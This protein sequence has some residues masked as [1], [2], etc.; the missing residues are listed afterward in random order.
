MAEMLHR[1]DIIRF[2]TMQHAVHPCLVYL[3]LHPVIESLL[4][5]TKG[6]IRW[7]PMH[8]EMSPSLDTERKKEDR[9]QRAAHL[10]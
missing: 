1:H 5:N 7:R 8:S 10:F 2:V 3:W 9:P 6:F 4:P